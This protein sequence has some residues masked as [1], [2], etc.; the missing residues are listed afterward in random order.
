MVAIRVD[1]L[2]PIYGVDAIE[3]SFYLL[4]ES[5]SGSLLVQV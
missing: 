3:L 4:L 1:V 2:V 5:L